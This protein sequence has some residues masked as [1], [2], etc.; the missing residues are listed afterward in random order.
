MPFLHRGQV[1]SFHFTRCFFDEEMK[2]AH[3]CYAFNDG[4]LTFEETVCFN[5]A[6]AFDHENRRRAFGLC[7]RLLHLA[8]GISYYKLFVPDEIKVDST[9]LTKEEADFSICFIRPVLGNF[10]TEITFL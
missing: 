2:T 4:A 9:V 7:L 8:A 3:L 6:P 1:Q 10:L 5:G